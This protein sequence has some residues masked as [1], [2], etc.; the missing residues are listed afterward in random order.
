M[1]PAELFDAEKLARIVD[2][3]KKVTGDRLGQFATF[4]KDLVSNILQTVGSQVIGKETGLGQEIAKKRGSFMKVIEERAFKKDDVSQ[5][6]MSQAAI[7]L[8]GVGDMGMTGADKLI[9]LV[10][11]RTK[12][13]SATKPAEAAD[14]RLVGD[15]KIQLAAQQESLYAGMNNALTSMGQTFA[16]AESEINAII[17][18]LANNTTTSIG[19]MKVTGTTAR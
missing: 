17:S 9:E 18:Q 14:P 4:G 6:L 1:T 2:P 16:N 13:V 7:A 10:G 11:A 12:P 3:D 5:G 15:Y 8:S 19:G